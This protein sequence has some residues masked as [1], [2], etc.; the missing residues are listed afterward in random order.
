[1]TGILIAYIVVGLVFVAG[2]IPLA[3]RKVRPN[4]WYGFRTK[5][6]MADERLWFAANTSAGRVLVTGGIVAILI[7]VFLYFQDV[8]DVEREA[9]FSS[10]ALML[11]TL[12]ML[13]V[14][15]VSALRLRSIKKKLGIR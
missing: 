5:A 1:M 4:P 2:G 9:R 7:V 3:M 14:I 10:S 12:D 6:T 13:V 15:I 8:P 11:V